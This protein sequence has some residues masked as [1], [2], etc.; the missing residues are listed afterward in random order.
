MLQ[1]RRD[2][3]ELIIETLAEKTLIKRKINQNVQEAFSIFKDVCKQLASEY[4][5]NMEEKEI[6]SIFD[7]N[8]KS[9]NEFELTI[10]GDLLLFSLDSNIFDFEKSH[11]IWRSSYVHNNTM[12]TFCG[13]IYIYNF[14]TDSLKNNRQNDIG[15]LIARIFVNKDNHYFV[16]GKRQL[17]FLYNDFAHAIFDAEQ[18]KRIVES[19]ILFTLDFDLLIPDYDMVN[20]ISVAKISENINNTRLQTGK[21]LGFKFTAD[22][23]DI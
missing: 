15:Y 10:G 11:P 21:R 1:K 3:K 9:R 5:T 20:M 6:F 4:N 7:Y 12:A 13:V 23:N 14:L 17:A 2:A 8:D 22:H 16:E 19:A 18:C